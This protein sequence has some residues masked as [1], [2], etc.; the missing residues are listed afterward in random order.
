MTISTEVSR[1]SYVGAGIVGPFAIPFFFAQA[2]DIKAVKTTIA[3]GTEV[4]LVPVTDYTLTGAGAPA[5]GS[6]TLIVALPA[7]HTISIV[8]VPPQKQSTVLDEATKFPAKT[9]ERSMDSLEVNVQRAI[10]LASRSIHLSDGDTSGVSLALP[11]SIQRPNKF[12]G[13]DGAGALMAA[14]AVTGIAVPVA[15]GQIIFGSGVGVSSD[16]ALVWDSINKRLSISGILIG[17]GGSQVASNISIGGGLAANTIGA[18]NISIGGQDTVAPIGFPLGA[19]TTGNSGLAIGHGALKSN[20]TGS[21]LAIGEGALR[22]CTTGTE[23]LA[24]GGGAGSA[25]TTGNTDVLVGGGCGGFISTGS[26]IVA[27]GVDA[28]HGTPGFE[29][30]GNS[31]TAIGTSALQSAT[32]T[33]DGTTALGAGAGINLT[34]GSAD[35]LLGNSAASSLTTES[36]ALYIDNQ[37]RGSIALDKAGALLYGTFNSTP[38]NQT[39]ALNAAVT[40]GHDGTLIARSGASTGFQRIQIANTTGSMQIGLESSTGGSI[41]TGSSAYATFLTSVGATDLQLGSNQAL[42]AT[43][44]GA[45]TVL[46]GTF[47]HG[48]TVAI[49]TSVALTNNA[50]ASVGT[51][52][53]APAAGNPTKWITINDNGTTRSIPAW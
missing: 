37:A 3:D 11:P 29:I 4:V 14:L 2:T 51:L 40:I 18:R 43:F 10:D 46:A 30:T 6:L 49:R 32:T 27:M 26:S 31:I 35:V 24:V 5:G 23:D 39:L 52:T 48:D 34:T 9:V 17:L 22:N 42:A 41:I 8:R 28:L 50:G 33:C 20:T 15:N 36:N 53:N 44:T 12:L 47:K 21:N 16:A 19:N 38:Q 7:T 25:I 1:V 13:F 45:N